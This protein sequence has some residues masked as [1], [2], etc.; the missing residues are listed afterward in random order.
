MNSSEYQ[1]PARLSRNY[2]FH[3]LWTST[4]AS[5]FADRLAMLAVGMMLG[6][7]VVDDI[8]G[9]LDDAAIVAGIN[10]WFF[11]P[12][13]IWGPFAGWLADRLPRKWLMFIADEMRGL[14]ILL[15]YL[16]LPD[17]QAGFV[18]GLYNT[19]FTIESLGLHFDHT[20]KVWAMMA[21]IGLFAATFSPARNSIIPNVVGYKFLQRA[22]SMVLGMGVIGNL[23][24]FG[25]GGTLAENALSACILTSSLCYI[26]PGFM[27]PFL[28]TP[29]VR[30]ARHVSPVG[31]PIAAVREVNRGGLYILRHKPLIALTAVS[32]L[33]WSG[34]QIIL[35]SGA[36]IAVG[37]Y[38]GTIEQFAL[39]G[40]GFGLG[41]LLGAVLLGVINSR[42]GGELMILAGMFGVAIFLALLT[43][44]PSMNIG[45][46]LAIGCGLCGGIIMISVNTMTQQLTAD[47]YRGRVM[48][49]KDLA[50]DAG[51]V[52]VS[53]AIWQME[54]AD[55]YILYVADVFAAALILA[56]IWG[57]RRY[58]M[59]GPIHRPG[60]NLLWRFTRLYCQAF[61]RLKIIGAHRVPRHGPVLIVAAHTAGV[62][63]LAI[64]AAL[65]RRVRWLMASDMMIGPLAF[66]WHA[67]E[68]IRVDRQKTD[69]TAAR[70]AIKALEDGQI[71]GIFPE[72]GINRQ[73][74]QLLPF[75]QGVSLIAL[76]AGCPIVP[77]A[78]HGTPKGGTAYTSILRFSHTRIEFGQPFTI[79][80]LSVDLNDRSDRH[81]QVALAIQ[82]RIS[83]LQAQGTAI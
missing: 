68:V 18:P 35:A 12:Y 47:G 57:T 24:G 25:I 4:F 16:M 36:A 26:V 61:H 5:G 45:I 44:V 59:R 6:Q 46:F 60:L 77:V 71:V 63:P 66:L 1:I 82:K 78:I 74:D 28:K 11:L 23:I 32:V 14:L 27:W 67:L 8:A 70:A 81:A 72:G 22:N 51:G 3:F 50:S 13:V 55:R 37:L 38:G 64:Q 39:I 73:T 58:A 34:S 49:F 42:I 65:P 33:F 62:D 21:A 29:V 80:D 76:R 83:D 53:L 31:G 30:H 79:N 56:A 75:A 69:R 40:G 2:S 52:L 43:V 17:G 10:F 20:S 54:Q 15:A 9:R 19:W 7:G 48:G 41:M